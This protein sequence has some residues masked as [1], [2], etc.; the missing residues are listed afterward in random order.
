[1]TL[2]LSFLIALAFQCSKTF[3]QYLYQEE[4]PF[5]EDELTQLFTPITEALDTN[6][7]IEDSE[8]KSLYIQSKSPR[9]KRPPNN[10]PQNNTLRNKTRQNETPQNPRD[11]TLKKELVEMG[12][13]SE[14]PVMLAFLHDRSC[15]PLS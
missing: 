8:D 14:N 5:T 10:T 15:P 4:E 13:L 2:T 11:V 1:M 9:N 3:Q 6:P 12:T 7:V